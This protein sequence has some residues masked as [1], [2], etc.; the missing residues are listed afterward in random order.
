[1][2][3][4]FGRS[5]SGRIKRIALVT[6]AAIAVAAIVSISAS[7]TSV[8]FASRADCAYVG[9]NV[10]A[11]RRFEALVHQTVSCAVVFNNAA[12][13]WT[14]W[15]RPWFVTSRNPDLRWG[16]WAVAPGTH[17][18]LVITQNLFPADLD[19]SDWLHAGA[20]GA[21]VQYAKT[22]AKNL[23]AAGLG[24]SVIRLAHEANNPGSAYA[25]GSTDE[26]LDLWREFWRRTAIAMRSVHGAHFLF[27]WT[28][29]AYYRPIPLQKWYPGNDVTDIIGIDAYD[30]GVPVGANRWRRI[31]TEQDGIRDVLR[32][33]AAHG[34]PVSIPEW[35]LAPADSKNLGGGDD[36]AYIDHMAEIVKDN[37][38][39][40][41][42]YFFNHDSAALLFAGHLSLAAYR[43]HF[44]KGGDA[45]GASTI[46]AS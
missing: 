28:I 4:I 33:A 19:G 46:S 7:G 26:D 11:L 6:I 35:G 16:A 42:S 40:Y 1:M 38:V 44:G 45:V 32:F 5:T 36:P 23:V 39:A 3:A 31:Y 17:R 12:P 21:Y 27:D 8:R 14:A 41:Q 29:N 20:A 30:S 15:E 10:Q 34:K 25:L 43:R 24:N 18:Q 22:L 13:N 9:T 2:R 37:P